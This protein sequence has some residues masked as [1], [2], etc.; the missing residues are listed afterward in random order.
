MV[1]PNSNA[2]M[3]YTFLENS[4][5]D[6][7]QPTREL[8]DAVLSAR[9]IC[10]GTL[11]Q[12]RPASRNAIHQCLQ[13]ASKDCSIVYDVNLRPPFVVKDWIAKSL[14]HATIVK[15]NDNE[16]KI[17]SQLFEF[18]SPDELRFAKRLLDDYK[19]LEL[20]CIT[21]GSQGCLAVSCDETIELAG[22]PVDV[23][24]TVG[25]GDAFTAAIIYGQLERWPLAKTLDLANRFGSLVAGRT[26]AM[27]SLIDELASLKSSLEWSYRDTHPS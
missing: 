22:I 25:A 24:D 7:L 10:F 18:P 14:K 19:Q 11:G 15:L 13:S 21:R 8:I 9:A 5:W 3:G 27:P 16:V 2:S 17:L 1:W 4:A 6:F 12:R 26:G 20:V 23:A